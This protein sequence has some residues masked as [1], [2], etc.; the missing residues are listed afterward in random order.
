MNFCES[1]GISWPVD[2]PDEFLENAWVMS[3]PAREQEIVV[4]DQLQN[5][6][7]KWTDSSQTLGRTRATTNEECPTCTPGGRFFCYD[8]MRYLTGRDLLNLQGYPWP[9][10]N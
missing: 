2:M 6:E 7:Y 1:L 8:R 3:S 5:P 9:G 4:L 10:L